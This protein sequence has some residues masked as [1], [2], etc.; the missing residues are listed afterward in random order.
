MELII[1]IGIISAVAAGFACAAEHS[2][3]AR[4]GWGAVE[5]YGAGALT[6]LIAFA[7]PLF[8]ALAVETAVLLYGMAWLI[9]GAMGFATW[10][11]YQKPVTL[12]EED[13]LSARIDRELGK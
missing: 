2:Y 4:H 9:I 5:R 3:A 6:W 12:P 1:L 11:S 7:P 10:A 13:E 8:A